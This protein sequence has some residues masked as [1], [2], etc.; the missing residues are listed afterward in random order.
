MLALINTLIARQSHPRG[1]LRLAQAGSFARWGLEGYV[2]SESNRLT[3]V[4][5]LARC[6]DLMGLEYDVRR[7][8][9]CL[10]ALFGLG[11]GFRAVAAA[12]MFAQTRK[13]G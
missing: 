5:L 10:A 2:I 4:W 11:A 1:L 9:A 13:S 8:G 7:Y 12:A 6:A 3:G